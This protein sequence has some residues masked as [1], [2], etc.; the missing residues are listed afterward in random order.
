ML[1]RELESTK[2]SANN[3]NERCS[4]LTEDNKIL[5]DSFKTLKGEEVPYSTFWYFPD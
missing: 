4:K 5:R 3:L 2:T 1:E